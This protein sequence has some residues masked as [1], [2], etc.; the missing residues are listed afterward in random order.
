MERNEGENV[1]FE[2]IVRD[3]GEDIYNAYSSVDTEEEIKS[4]IYDAIANS[5]ADYVAKRPDPDSGTRYWIQISED[6]TDGVPMR[7]VVSEN[8]FIIDAYP[9][10]TIDPF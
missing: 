4:K 7:V 2:S 9:D 3:H 5:E 1:G 8:G 10:S 6:R